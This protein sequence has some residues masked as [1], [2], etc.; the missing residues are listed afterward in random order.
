MFRRFIRYYQPYRSIF[1]ADMA[2]AFLTA[3]TGIA[4]PMITRYTLAVLGTKEDLHFL[5][6]A[7]LILAFVYFCR[8]FLR[9][10]IQYYGHMIGVRMQAAMRSDLFNKFERL[11]I[12]FFDKEETGQLMSRAINDLSDISELAH[13]GPEN[14]L[15]STV[16]IIASFFYLLSINLRLTLL[17]YSC[18]PFLFLIVTVLKKRMHR[19]FKVAREKIARINAMI[20]NS[21][22]GIRVTKAFNNAGKE[23]AKFTG[24]N[25]EFIDA[26]AE[27]YRTMAY[28]NASTGFICDIFN[29]ICLVA[30]GF[31]LYKGSLS[32]ADYSAFIVSINLFL[33]PVN[34]LVS[35]M[36]QYQNAASG[37]ERFLEIIDKKEEDVKEGG[38]KSM[39]IQGK[40]EFR[41]VSF[42]YDEKEIL[43]HIDFT[44]KPACTLAL[45][46]AT[47]GGKTT[48]CHLLPR[49]YQ[50]TSGAI[51]LDGQNIAD[52]NLTF[53]R[54]QIGIVAQDVFLFTGSIYEN[55]LYGKITATYAE[56]VEAAK[57]A[58][59]YD[60]IM[61]LPQGFATAVGERGVRLSGGQKQR[62]A[63][64][65]LFLKNPPILILDEAT[66]ALDNSTEYAIQQALAKLCAQRTTL[67][68]AHRLSTVKNADEILVIEKGMI[69][70]RGNH[71]SLLAKGG[72][73]AQ[74]YALQFTLL[75]ET[76]GELCIE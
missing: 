63:I 9:Y 45:V 16:M 50:P 59:I 69:V 54:E 10:F 5:W 74:L 21:I 76:Q 6:T 67:V 72:I 27:S 73:Y 17:V 55:I 14:L 40:I 66:S 23:L 51:Y 56:V 3:V 36:E 62:I 18:L 15:I 34:T 43:K 35:F 60:F 52:F 29:V 24:G 48:I 57:A 75:D 68:V 46:G 53:L 61:S 58:N 4:Y 71:Q 32:F 13:H 2:A 28:F 44:L 39:P 12:A 42:A 7:G 11:P 37:F 26:K 64:A 49:F 33:A 31:Y 47:G 30:G 20:E 38:I 65:R 22:A 8:M 25:E 41:D 70:E 19:A 1:M